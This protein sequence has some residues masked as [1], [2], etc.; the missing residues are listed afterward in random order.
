MVPC[1][2]R[3][4]SLS[5]AL[6]HLCRTL[7]SHCFSTKNGESIVGHS[8]IEDI[9]FDA[10]SAFYILN[11]EQNLAKTEDHFT[12]VFKDKYTPWTGIASRFPTNVECIFP[13]QQAFSYLGH[14]NGSQFLMHA[15]KQGERAQL[16]SL[17]FGC[18]SAKGKWSGRL[19]P[20]YSIFFQLVM[21]CPTV[22]GYLWNV[23]DGDSD[24]FTTRLFQDWLCENKT[25]ISDEPLPVQ[26]MQASRACKMRNLIGKA[27]VVYGLPVSASRTSLFPSSI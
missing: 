2:S 9:L 22:L 1:V 13:R 20:F 8:T 5:L 24:R 26:S 27:A 19:E 23:T 11:P 15:Y 12:K 14:G 10:K 18:S 6:S 3:N 17:L 16:I 21:G 25:N 4:F 7:K